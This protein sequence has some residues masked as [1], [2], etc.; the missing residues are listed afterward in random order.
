MEI[1]EL[2]LRWEIFKCSPGIC[3]TVTSKQAGTLLLIVELY[4]DKEGKG[5]YLALKTS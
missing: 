1:C 4:Q 3:S 2:S 5:F